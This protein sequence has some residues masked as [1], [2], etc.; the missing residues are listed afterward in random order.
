MGVD[1]PGNPISEEDI[2][3]ALEGVGS[4]STLTRK[5]SS[6][7]KP[8]DKPT[9]FDPKDGDKA[10]KQALTDI[11]TV[12]ASDAPQE[13]KDRAMALKVS[14]EAQGTD[15]GLE[16]LET[17]T[18]AR[19]RV[20][21]PTDN[22]FAVLGAVPASV[23]SLLKE[24]AVDPLKAEESASFK[25]FVDQ[26][27][28]GSDD[29]ER[30][31]PGDLSASITDPLRGVIDR[32]EEAGNL[33][34]FL[35][36]GIRGATRGADYATGFAGEVLLDPLTYLTGGGSQLVSLSDDV[37]KLGAK[38]VIAESGEGTLLRTVT[39]EAAERGLT[40][41]GEALEALRGAVDDVAKR[42]AMDTLVMEL[43]K[44]PPDLA[45]HDSLRPAAGVFKPKGRIQ[46]APRG[47]ALPEL[48]AS[49]GAGVVD[50]QTLARDVLGARHYG[51]A[52]IAD[53]SLYGLRRGYTYRLPG[54][55]GVAIEA[56]PNSKTGPL[57]YATRLADGGDGYAAA[58][59]QWLSTRFKASNVELN[60]AAREN[61]I[62]NRAIE[63]RSK[64]T[65]NPRLG[66]NDD[67]FLKAI[68]S[69]KG[70]RVVSS[71]AD[72]HQAQYLARVAELTS[73][74]DQKLEQELFFD[75]VSP[76]RGKI[77]ASVW[78]DVASATEEAIAIEARKLG[79]TP[80][81]L[82]L[83]GDGTNAVR[84]HIGLNPATVQFENVAGQIVDLDLAPLAGAYAYQ[85]SELLA[86]NPE[87]PWRLVEYAQHG[88]FKNLGEKGGRR[89][90]APS[91][92]ANA[93]FGSNVIGQAE[94]LSMWR[95]WFP[96]Q[97]FSAETDLIERFLTRISEVRELPR[98]SQIGSKYRTPVSEAVK[99]R[100]R[101]DGAAK[102]SRKIRERKQA[103]IDAITDKLSRR[104]PKA[105]HDKLIV[106]REAI[107]RELEAGEA[108]S[109]VAGVNVVDGSG[110]VFDEIDLAGGIGVTKEEVFGLT[111]SVDANHIEKIRDDIRRRTG[112]LIEIRGEMG[113]RLSTARQVAKALD[114]GD[115]GIWRSS[116]VPREVPEEAGSTGL[117]RVRPA[118]RSGK[119]TGMSTFQEQV[120]KEHLSKFRASR[121][122]RKRLEG[123]GF[124]VSSRVPGIIVHPN[125]TQLEMHMMK[126]ADDVVDY[127]VSTADINAGSLFPAPGAP[128]QVVD[129]FSPSAFSN[130]G[131]F[132]EFRWTMTSVLADT[133]H[134]DTAIN[135]GEYLMSRVSE[136]IAVLEASSFVSEPEVLNWALENPT[137]TIG[138]LLDQS[139]SIV[140][141][142]GKELALERPYEGMSQRFAEWLQ[143]IDEENY[144][145]L[146][147]AMFTRPTELRAEWVG[148]L[149]EQLKH[150]LDLEAVRQ[151]S[152]DLMDSKTLAELDNLFA[153][154]NR[155]STSFD[156]QL[157][158]QS[159][160]QF[161]SEVNKRWTEFLAITKK[162]AFTNAHSRNMDGW[163]NAVSDRMGSKL[164]EFGGSFMAVDSNAGEAAKM[165]M[166]SFRSDK[167]V[168]DSFK[169]LHDASNVWRAM[170][171]GVPGFSINNYLGGMMQMFREGVSITSIRKWHE[172]APVAVNATLDEVQNLLPV[173]TSKLWDKI[174]SE[175]D[176][177]AMKAVYGH[178][179]ADVSLMRAVG[180]NISGMVDMSAPIHDRVRQAYSLARDEGRRIGAYADAFS[181]G[182]HGVGQKYDRF[183]ATVADRMWT[184]GR[185]S[186]SHAKDV[187]GWE[188]VIPSVEGHLRGA[189]MLDRLL[190]GDTVETAV[191]DTLRIH[192]DYSDL[193]HA[194]RAMNE[195][196][197]FFTWR[198][199][200][201]AHQTAYMLQNP[202]R[203]A[204]AWNAYN[205]SEEARGVPW[206]PHW[207][208]SSTRF[209]TDLKVGGGSVG[210]TVPDPF[211]ESF[212]RLGVVT[213]P[214]KGTIDKIASLTLAEGSPLWRSFL[215]V[216]TGST[217]EGI[218]IQG[219][220]G[221]LVR[222]PGPK[223]LNQVVGM[224]FGAQERDDGWF[225]A[226]ARVTH[227]LTENLPILSQMDRLSN[228][229]GGL[230]S[231]PDRVLVA[232]WLGY[233][234][235]RTSV[236]SERTQ[237]GEKQ[238]IAAEARE[239]LK[240]SKRLGY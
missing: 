176:R 240:M 164:Y 80:D 68:L 46:P 62:L 81:E 98:P 212:S 119:K 70:R 117:S 214:S 157:T 190:R 125:P 130:K 1:M 71:V 53:P 236:I 135:A 33:P 149:D 188:L 152:G 82:M 232:S 140:K 224:I 178:G 41:P 142:G 111:H 151:T 38:G 160:R 20:P 211:A 25:D 166:N 177:M 162:M 225:Y 107:I 222:L 198:S 161:Q 136:R 182:L 30:F 18:E 233:L 159:I 28:F 73:G 124:N 76:D 27:G 234:G 187:G 44:L 144:N 67:S 219:R 170:A 50:T 165:V 172:L 128:S 179:V 180:S 58:A 24:V 183:W 17:A 78:N 2:K 97:I 64:E 102:A 36:T 205:E 39:V 118:K 34:G 79:I 10:I 8:V 91:Q 9:D 66:E 227:V 175:V 96:G 239:V 74:L 60:L 26:L 203:Y 15:Y 210:L 156:G 138:D 189:T 213:D 116:F 105:T 167:D 194:D 127:V 86:R 216:G 229:R 108:I 126:L 192:I 158:D 101:L 99:E 42:Q 228:D 100:K 19:N 201:L 200:S 120:A 195:L 223:Q 47:G 171:V 181:M 206:S 109:G 57:R 94:A 29:V 123:L 139:A 163:I 173:G 12:L 185:R 112:A 215:E 22:L 31:G 21:T 141:V 92:L 191:R 154:V 122:W 32:Q 184:L 63:T 147:A 4:S 133:A 207:A 93:R 56:V 235:L 40:R 43:R 77:I 13:L 115:D 87:A 114:L 110:G 54:T 90:V 148:F 35:A 51:I 131:P 208:T 145:V 186:T 143:A 153:H 150:L 104:L 14:I 3:N 174:P 129:A 55:R 45:Y 6:T 132:Q 199:R 220:G 202:T 106:R 61:V 209:A 237:W 89:M 168:K 231:R 49:R 52:G 113:E 155:T 137:A 169:F 193:T 83:S 59:V 37:V 75:P 65:V 217:A 16:G 204:A 134:G 218:E 146:Q 103:E 230:D 121:G 95:Q 69:E 196:F 226:D 11:S 7:A 84:E 5:S 88:S 72:K 48:I 85:I 221:D 238:R 197:P 23:S